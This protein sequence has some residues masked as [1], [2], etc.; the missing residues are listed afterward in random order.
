MMNNV[1]EIVETVSKQNV[2]GKRRINNELNNENVSSICSSD[3][4]SAL[5]K[6]NNKSEFGH[7]DNVKDSWLNR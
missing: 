1:N 3:L 2:N 6:E 7:A 5:Y 4:T